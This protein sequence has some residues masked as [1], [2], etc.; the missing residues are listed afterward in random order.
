MR[1]RADLHPYQGPAI[2]FL[3][4]A[5]SRFLIAAMGSGKTAIALHALVDLIAAGAVRLPVLVCAPLLVASTVWAR[6][7]ECDVRVFGEALAPW[8]GPRQAH[9]VTDPRVLGG[10]AQ[11]AGL[12]VERLDEV[13]CTFDY[14]DDDAVL[15]PLFDSTLGRVA[16]HRAGPVA[17]RDAVLQRLGP[18]RTP[19]GG[20]RLANVVRVLVA[21]PR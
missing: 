21:R 15:G 13:V 5:K 8:L 10:M 20:Y 9:P 19:A 7:E 6:E 3:C 11:R 4:A 17:L 14:E 12:V 16:G 2:D 18:Y 1:T